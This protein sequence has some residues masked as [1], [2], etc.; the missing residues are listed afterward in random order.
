M[1]QGLRNL[2]ADLFEYQA[3][4]FTMMLE[5]RP[6]QGGVYPIHGQ[7]FDEGEGVVA[8][9][10]I[11]I[12]SDDGVAFVDDLDQFG[13]FHVEVTVPGT[14]H[15]TV[16]TKEGAFAVDELEVGGSSVG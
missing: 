10:R 11:V 13:E 14:Y 2:S 8:G 16:W 5:N 15:V 4:P 3:G 12:A 9:S 1:V 7:V 6:F